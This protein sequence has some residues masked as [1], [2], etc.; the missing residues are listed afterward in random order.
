MGR[1][2]KLGR[3]GRREDSEKW[4]NEQPSAFPGVLSRAEQGGG[5]WRTGHLPSVRPQHYVE[6]MGHKPLPESVLC[7][8]AGSPGAQRGRCQH[9]P[10]GGAPEG[11]GGAH[12]SCPFS[13]RTEAGSL[14]S[15]P[16]SPRRGCQTA[17]LIQLGGGGKGWATVSKP[18]MQRA[19]CFY[20]DCLL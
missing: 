19:R 17:P 13:Q 5:E 4:W 6:A 16:A 3:S 8:D 7:P 10:A 14:S 12:L 18:H 1:G 2:S 20:R 11:D 15:Q 9:S